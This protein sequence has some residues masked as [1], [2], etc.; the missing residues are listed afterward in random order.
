MDR[1]SK[2]PRQRGGRD[3][4]K[5]GSRGSYGGQSWNVKPEDEIKPEGDLIA[6]II[7]DSAETGATSKAPKIESSKCVASYNWLEKQSGTM[8]IPGELRHTWR[9]RYL[10]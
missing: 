6:T 4:G 1:R 10:P 5:F 2:F 3:R 9:R 7:P 8:L